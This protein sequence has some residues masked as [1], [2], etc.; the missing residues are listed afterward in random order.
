M[1]EEIKEYRT[2]KEQCQS[3]IKG[4]CH[5]CGGELQPVETIDNSGH[6]TFWAACLKC[7]KFDYGCDPHIFEIAKI[8]V[9]EHHHVT[10]PSMAKPEEIKEELYKEYW[11]SSQIRGTC[12]L[13]RTILNIHNQLKN[14]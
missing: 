7:D 1:T 12:G 5:G 10:Y 13:V 2:T 3:S 4:V 11:L 9:T 6:P 8:M 14:K